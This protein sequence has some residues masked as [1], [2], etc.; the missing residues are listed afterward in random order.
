MLT[1]IILINS[2]VNVFFFYYT[3]LF[4]IWLFD[5]SFLAALIVREIWKRQRP[6]N[7]NIRHV[8][9]YRSLPNS[10][11]LFYYGLIHVRGSPSEQS[12][13]TK[14]NFFITPY[15]ERI[16]ACVYTCKNIYYLCKM[17]PPIFL[18]HSF[19]FTEIP[20]VRNIQ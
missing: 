6:A 11:E 14:E 19:R 7:N 16:I 1:Y 15:P 2:L 18:L 17:L 10:L 8:Q 20:K 4:L 3:K 13:S 12:R 5:W 9:K